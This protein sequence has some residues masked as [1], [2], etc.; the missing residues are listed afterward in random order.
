[1][2]FFKPCKDTFLAIL[3]KE[4]IIAW[5]FIDNDLW[6]TILPSL[7]IFMAAWIEGSKA[8]QELPLFLLYSLLYAWLYILTFC[9]SNQLAGIEED[10]I[11]K[12]YRPLVTGLVTVKQTR[13][14]LIA[15]NLIYL[16]IAYQLEI[17][18]FSVAWIFVSLKLN[19]FGWSDHWATKNL[20]GMTLGTVILFNVQWRI[21]QLHQP[22]SGETQLYFLFLSLWAGFALPLQDMRDQDGD[23][24]AGRKTLPIALGDQKARIVLA[25]HFSLLSPFL[26]LAAML[27]QVPLPTLVGNVWGLILLALQVLIHLAIAYRI[28]KYRNANSD[29]KTYLCYVF[30]FCAAIPMICFL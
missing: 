11:N 30:F 21:A 1:M 8:W 19:L 24:K 9:L 6:D 23:R 28:I 26:F 7:I 14:R 22:I 10:R 16:V 27:T 3:G 18:W 13:Y 4:F 15:Y 2:L 12:P 20:L 25:T 5:R 17:F 29:H